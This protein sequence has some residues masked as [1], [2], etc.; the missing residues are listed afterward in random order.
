MRCLLLWSLAALGAGLASAKTSPGTHS[1]AL[2]VAVHVLEV[3]R[4]AET[5]VTASTPKVFA[6]VVADGESCESSVEEVA[7][8]ASRDYV[9]RME[10]G[11]EMFAYAPSCLPYEPDKM[12]DDPFAEEA[13]SAAPWDFCDPQTAGMQPICQ[14]E[15][16]CHCWKTSTA[17]QCV[18]PDIVPDDEREVEGT[19][20][21][22][23]CGNSDRDC[24]ESD[25]CRFTVSG[26]RQCG[27]KPY[28]S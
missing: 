7:M 25:Y 5:Q 15:F 19:D 18:P 6:R 28:F 14:R 1:H 12:R 20:G 11:K 21:A 8:C 24:A 23:K 10:V 2:H 27:P 16:Q 4:A 9:C 22:L 3:G 26:Q 17:C 13:T